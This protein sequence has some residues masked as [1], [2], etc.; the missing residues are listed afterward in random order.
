[1]RVEKKVG[2]LGQKSLHGHG[3]HLTPS[4]KLFS[5]LFGLSLGLADVDK[6]LLEK[7]Q[8]K[9]NYSASKKLTLVRRK[10]I[11]NNILLSSFWYFVSVWGGTKKGIFKNNHF[12]KNYLW[13][14]LNHNCKFRVT[15]DQCCG[16]K[17][18]GV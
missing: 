6:F 17:K 2:R 12:L 7:V 1:L 16:K 18:M 3:L 10:V 9:L 15:W 8:H 13:A 4:L 14:R 5:T 11:V